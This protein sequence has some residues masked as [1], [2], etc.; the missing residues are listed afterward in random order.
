VSPGAKKFIELIAAEI[1]EEF[2]HRDRNADESGQ[3]QRR[4][5]RSERDDD[6]PIPHAKAT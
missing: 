4:R 6:T 2:L 5:D 3:E 1:A